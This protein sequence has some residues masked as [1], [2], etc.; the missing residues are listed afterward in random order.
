MRT[1]TRRGRGAV[2]AGSTTGAATAVLALLSAGAL[3]TLGLVTASEISG[4]FAGGLGLGQGAA[5]VPPGKVVVAGKEPDGPRGSGGS[6]GGGRDAGPQAPAAGPT[7]VPPLPPDITNDLPTP[8]GFGGVPAA[9]PPTD[10]PVTGP[11]PADPI[12]DVVL[13]PPVD[14]GLRVMAAHGRSV[15][16]P[17]HTKSPQ[18]QSNAA[19]GRA[20]GKTPTATPAPAPATTSKTDDRPAVV[21]ASAP[22]PSATAKPARGAAP[23]RLAHAG[24]ARAARPEAKAHGTGPEAKARGTGPEAKAQRKVAPVVPPLVVPT[25][26]AT[27]LADPSAGGP[28]AGDPPGLAK[29]RADR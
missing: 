3:A 16:A 5:P 1:G 22:A 17:G 26:A 28:P 24:K 14:A 12:P 7:L 4:G 25:P 27:A 13:Q 19:D 29:G 21:F 11:P 23:G 18:S 6:G 2:D 20:P 9:A 15:L 10:A 8:A